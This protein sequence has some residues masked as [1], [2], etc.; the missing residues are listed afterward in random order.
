MSCCPAHCF[1]RFSMPYDQV[2]TFCMVMMI[3]MMMLISLRLVRCWKEHLLQIVAVCSL[4]QQRCHV[5]DVEVCRRRLRF[6]HALSRSSVIE[7]NPRVPAPEPARRS[8]FSDKNLFKEGTVQIIGGD[9][10]A[11]KARMYILH[12]CIIPAA[13]FG[14]VSA[15]AR[16]NLQMSHIRN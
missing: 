5:E 14:S 16:S 12:A 6:Q 13:L 10:P 2:V 11:R 8:A 3:M 15:K 9:T 1:Q 7:A 4:F